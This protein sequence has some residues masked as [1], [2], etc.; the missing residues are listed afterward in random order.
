MRGR[1][2]RGDLRI[3]ALDPSEVEGEPKRPEAQESK[4]FRP[5][6]IAWGQEGDGLWGRLRN[7]WSAGVRL[8]FSLT[9]KRQ[10]GRE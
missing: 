10:S 2:E 9:E 6:L 8:V 1:D 3:E 7:R 4:S 5:E